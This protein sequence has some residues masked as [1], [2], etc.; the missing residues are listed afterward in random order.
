M[1]LQD[2]EDKELGIKN[3]ERKGIIIQEVE[4]CVGCRVSG[5]KQ[6]AE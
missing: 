5:I 2:V 3:Y 6:M 1:Q 4:V